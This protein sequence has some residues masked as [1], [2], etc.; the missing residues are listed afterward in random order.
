LELLRLPYSRLSLHVTKIASGPVVVKQ[1]FAGARDWGLI[2]T[3]GAVGG[4]I[5]SA[6]ALR[7]RPERPLLVG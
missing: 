3:G 4:L 1:H 7:Y 5:G 2:L 6:I